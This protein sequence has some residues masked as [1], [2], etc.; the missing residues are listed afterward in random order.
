MRR[1]GTLALRRFDL[2]LDGADVMRILGCGPGRTV[3]RALA[4]L[5]DC[6]V[7]DPSRNTPEALRALL[8]S[9]ASSRDAR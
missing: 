5:T 6:V 3:G 7:E 4:H 2:A 8:E 1:Q 9:W